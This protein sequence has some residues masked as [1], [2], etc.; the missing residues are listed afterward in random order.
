MCGRRSRLTPAEVRVLD[1]AGFTAEGSDERGGKPRPQNM[2]PAAQDDAQAPGLDR[3]LESLPTDWH[4]VS[5]AGFLR[6]PHPDIAIDG[7][8]ATPLEW[9]EYSGGDTAPVLK[10]AEIAEWAAR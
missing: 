3:L 2:Q 4:P 6:T 8:P 9:L 7:R 5:I 10:L 1:A